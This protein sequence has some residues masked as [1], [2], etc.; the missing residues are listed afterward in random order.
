MC[1]RRLL[2]LPGQCSLSFRR[3]VGFHF[4]E[5]NATLFHKHLQSIDHVTGVHEHN[6]KLGFQFMILR[7]RSHSSTERQ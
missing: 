5:V 2:K 3:W 7:P 6:D 4:L 1:L